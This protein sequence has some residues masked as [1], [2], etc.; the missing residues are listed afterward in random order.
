MKY[1]STLTR[2]IYYTVFVGLFASLLT[3]GRHSV[4]TIHQSI[5][6]PLEGGCS[7]LKASFSPR[8]KEEL[9]SLITAYKAQKLRNKKYKKKIGLINKIVAAAAKKRIET[10]NAAA[11]AL[12]E[13]SV[14]QAR[15]AKIEAAM[16][17]EMPEE[18]EADESIAELLNPS[19]SEPSY[20]PPQEHLAPVYQ[21]QSYPPSIQMA[22]PQMQA[23][24]VAPYQPQAVPSYQPP[25]AMQSQPM[26]VQP[27]MGYY[28]QNQSVQI[29]A[30]AMQLQASAMA[31][32]AQASAMMMQS[33][34]QQMGMVPGMMMPAPMTQ[35][36]VARP[37]S[38]RIS[39]KYE[40][41]LSRREKVKRLMACFQE[42]AHTCEH[43]IQRLLLL[44]DLEFDIIE[45]LLS[46]NSGQLVEQAVLER[47][48]TLKQSSPLIASAYNLFIDL[49][50]MSNADNT[51]VK[52]YHYFVRKGKKV[53]QSGTPQGRKKSLIQMRDVLE[54][55][56]EMV[57][58]MQRVVS[59]VH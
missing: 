36:Q 30:M 55:Y 7:D 46:G 38:E 53:R 5:F 28:P 59:F 19:Y 57:E 31:M 42:L 25:M 56:Y 29:A 34:Q 32:Q 45:L 20:S 54:N 26:M 1:A 27:Q 50:T 21:Q 48:R 39:H 12:K 16:E 18:K 23:M 14:E 37:A 10:R 51:D 3:I 15:N 4:H 41:G 35:P 22:Q 6:S 49:A 9:D 40:S 58:R 8:K 2:V 11:M 44:L 17:V 43:D 47:N 24:S 13:E 52:L 33:Q